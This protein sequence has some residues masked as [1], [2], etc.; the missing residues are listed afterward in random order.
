[1][2][3][4]SVLLIALSTLAAPVAWAS[5]KDTKDSSELSLEDI[6]KTEV[7]TASR[8]AQQVNDTAAAVFVITREDIQRSGAT[9]IPEAL[10]MAPGVSVARL[11]ANRYVVSVRGFSGRFADKLLVLVDGRSIYS[12]LFSGVLW[13]FEDTMLEDV[14]RIEVIRGPGG[15]LWGANAVNAVIN[16]I[17]RKSRD[18]KGGLLIAGTGTSERAF[19]ALRYGGELANGSY[20][21]WAQANDLNASVDRFGNDA[22]DEARTARLGFR[23]DWTLAGGNRLTV[24]GAGYDQQA[25]DRWRVASV[26]SPF[27]FV[28]TDVR[29]E[30]K[31]AHVLARHDWA[32]SGDSE[33]S[34]QMYFNHS[35]L[36][37]PGQLSE[38]RNTFDI[39]FQRRSIT[40]SHDLVYGAG[41]RNSRD[42]TTSAGMY[43]LKPESATFAL[44][45]AFVQDDWTVVPEKLRLIGG[46]RIEHNTYTGVEPQPSARFIWTP[47][48]DSSVWGAASRAIRLPSR[49]EQD[50]EADLGAA[51]ARGPVPAVLIRR[52]KSPDKAVA[53]K[54]NTYELGYRMR[55]S[56]NLSV[57][58]AAFQADYKN[59]RSN[60]L[61]AQ[62]VVIAPPSPYILQ[63]AFAGNDINAT[64]RGVEISAEWQAA[65]WWRLQA[66]YSN[67]DINAN[68]TINNPA[69]ISGAAFFERADPRHQ[70]SLR[71]AMTFN[72][73]HQFDAWLRYVGER[74]GTP[75]TGGSIASYTDLDLRYGWRATNAFDFSVGGQNLLKRRR[76]EVIPDLL[77]S[78]PVEFER[79]FYVKGKWQF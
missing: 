6:L 35:E 69:T 42:T 26:R 11:A 27:G 73:R 63:R 2:L 34:L 53:E 66:S 74:T 57:D 55:L 79:S 23:T 7:T 14:E 48:A 38:R 64:G 10:R 70:L 28:P 5:A 13:E 29:E 45:S 41:Y 24:S 60:R 65:P 19:G 68:A 9:V 71:S 52:F 33:A 78:E 76:A 39:D 18:T 49:G 67:L 32:L 61:G 51:P 54:V 3:K 72:K 43:M 40:R 50:A 31:G 25:K 4:P 30:G 22:N 75:E 17:T 62:E 36:V 12:P 37:V 77:P 46:L 21:V 20:R 56:T 16:I 1:M 8:K 15:S 47:T 44:T 58:V 59:L